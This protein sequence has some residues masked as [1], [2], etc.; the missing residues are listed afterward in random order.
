MEQLLATKLFIP[1]IRPKLVSRTRLIEQ[2][3]AGLHRKLTLISAPA[4]FG[5]TTV[6]REWV[7]SVQNSHKKSDQT[8]YGIAWLSLD[9]GDNDSTRFLTY[10][11]SALNRTT[12]I[13]TAIGEK[14]LS[15]LQSTQSP[16]AEI[17]LTTLINDIATLPG[18]MIFILD[19]Y[20]L[21]DAQS[22]HNAL[23]FFIENIP[24]QIHLVI[25]TREDP[26]L[27]LSRLR[28]RDQLTEL[29]ATDLRFSTSE[30]AEFLNQ[31][32]GLNLSTE[33]ITAL[34]ARTEG[35]IAGLQLAAISLQGKADTTKLIKSFSGSHRLVL[36]Y[37]IE[38]VLEQ[39]AQNVQDFLLQTAI[40]DR[41][42]GSL[43]DALTGQNNGQATLEALE[44][45]NMFIVPLDNERGWY[46]YH[47][48]FADLL[49]Q[50]LQQTQPEQLP[51]LHLRASEW[52]EQK[53]FW[54][55]AVRH[56]FAAEDF[57][58]AADL[59][60]LAWIPMNTSYQSVTWLGWAK[61]LPDELV[62]TRPVL[63]TSCGWASLDTGD[64]EAAKRCFQ[65]AE[66]WLDTMGN[67]DG[68]LDEEEFRSLSISIANGRAYLAQAVGDVVGTIK[69][70]QRATDLLRENDHFERGLADVLAGFA[71]WASG[72]LDTAYKAI[73]DAILE[74]QIAD[75]I[76]FIISFTSYLADIMI[77]QGRL[78]ETERNY[79]QL[80]EFVAGQGESEVKETAVLHLGLSEIYLEQGDLEVARQHLEKSE[81]LGEQPSFPPWYRHWICA[82]ARIMADQ[83]DW[84]GIIEMFKG[85]EH[86]YY[87]HP[88]PDIRPLK[89]LLARMWLAQGKLVEVQHWAR[90]QDLSVEDNLSHLREFEH[91]TLARLLIAQYKSDLIDNYIHDAIKLL[92]R[93]LKAAEDGGRMGSVIEILVLEALAYKAQSDTPSA[94]V[95]L[96]RALALAESEGYMRIYV[97][98]GMPMMTLLGEIEFE[99][100]RMRGYVDKL[101]ASFREKSTQT[102]SPNAQSLIEPLSERE[103]EILQLIAEGLTNQ[104]IGFQLYLSLNT[105]KAHTRNI[106]GKLEVNSRT[107]AVAKARA[108]EILSPA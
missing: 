101:L 98:E 24:P 19:D 58:R 71:Y 28:A 11:I 36:D 59:I 84:D 30:A 65:D 37:L 43:C 105:V 68:Q 5:K 83:G 9:E 41:L 20:H 15:M 66:Q 82:H 27:P 75:R 17:V 104:E 77:A 52:Y 10:F 81:E 86:L 63:S 25:A 79:L 74:M 73:A 95:S 44:Q 51:N 6:V 7:D 91:I 85:A 72:N 55:D 67:M 8:N 94:L 26:F 53:G 47:H 38:E 78:H 1:T 33:D 70:T 31:V 12:G 21:I 56:A 18:K 3:S 35:W 54:S 96:K 16:P 106:Y 46:R 14:A 76:P 103:I 97:S 50:R 89:A 32:M 34:E 39:Q 49:R 88:I 107:Q 69:Y 62:R 100:V 42:T 29:R 80:L 64:L 2:L 87:R 48:L 13:E 92:E 4:G 93:L 60:E 45:A 99:D 23:N 90:E 102:S 108:L 57:K 40:L 61:A 22:I